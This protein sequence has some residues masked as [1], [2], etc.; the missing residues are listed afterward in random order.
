MMEGSFFLASSKAF[1]R[2]LS[3]SP[4][5]FDMISGPLIQKKRS[6]FISHSAANESF[7]VQEVSIKEVSSNTF[8]SIIN[9][10][11][12]HTLSSPGTDTGTGNGVRNGDGKRQ[13]QKF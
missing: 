4:A 8:N 13:N 9:R 12:M 10:Q 6:S 7:R 5:S 2:L 1:M 11:E 3:L